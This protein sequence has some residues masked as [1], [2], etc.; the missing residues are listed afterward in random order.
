MFV[1]LYLLVLSSIVHKNEEYKDDFRFQKKFGKQFF[2]KYMPLL[3]KHK[4]LEW[5]ASSISY[6]KMALTTN[7]FV[8][9][10][11]TYM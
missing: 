7:L 11:A 6:Q 4:H 10:I 3:K 5:T 1:L 9:Q 2:S 8:G